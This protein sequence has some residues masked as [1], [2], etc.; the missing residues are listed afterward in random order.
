MSSSVSS[1]FLAGRSAALIG[2][3]AVLTILAAGI[4]TGIIVPAGLG[5]DFANFY[6]TGRRALAGQIADIYDPATLIEGQA[7]Q[8]TM[9]FWGTPLSAFLYA[10]LAL[11]RPSAALVVFK[12]VGTAAYVAGLWLLWREV[13]GSRPNAAFGARDAF[14]GALIIT[15]FQPFWT[16]YRV[17]GQT[18][19]LVFV[20]VVAGLAAYRRNRLAL[21]TLCLVGASLVKPAFLLVPLLLAFIG[22]YRMFATIAAGFAMTAL[23][24]VAL[25]GWPIH[26]VFVTVVLRGAGVAS[27]W[28]FNSSIYL[29]A[30][31]GR[32]LVSSAPVGAAEDPWAQALRIVLR[33]VVVAAFIE[34]VRLRH[35]A[36]VDGAGRR[37]FDFLVAVS[38]TLLL[39]Q[40]VWEHYL[41]A[42]FI[43]V[44]FMLGWRSEFPPSA[45][46][47]LVALLTLC[48]GQSLIFIMFLRSHLTIE[49]TVG[50]LAITLFKAG[51]L[52]VFL[53]LLVRYRREWIAAAAR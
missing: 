13:R 28:F 43:P 23:V 11:L 53:G 48:M 1:R 41:A 22:G 5:W 17:G 49:T 31:V 32:P 39:S 34:L 35:R 15:L 3:A 6:D 2:L 44:A 50:L 47:W 20:L 8:G 38:F 30:D 21:T 12:T 7:G 25:L 40:V 24:S 16:M 52:L 42:L 51:P 33:L 19:P 18:T 45:R 29:L 9:R 4:L 10:P 27:P 37:R 36:G 46:R 14:F 26:Q